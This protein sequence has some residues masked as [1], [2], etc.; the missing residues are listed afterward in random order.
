MTR[1][2]I[3]K[4]WEVILLNQFHDILPGSSIKEVYE[5]TKVEYAALE[6]RAHELIEEK[7][8]AIAKALR[9]KKDDLVVFNSL[10]F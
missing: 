3:Y 7:T 1:E 2:E 10:S 6:K 8:N 4:S 5:V 9:A